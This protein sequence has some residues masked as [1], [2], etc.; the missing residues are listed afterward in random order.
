MKSSRSA[1]SALAGTAIL[2]AAGAPAAAET[3]VISRDDCMRVVRHVPSADVAY[4]PGADVRGRPVAPAD[5][6]AASPLRLPETLSFDLTIDMARYLGG[7]RYGTL[8]S[9]VGTIR[10][11]TASG[12][13]TFGDQPLTDADQRAVAAACQKAYGKVR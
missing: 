13:L 3:V 1:W 11:D 10:Y 9:T 4:A 5:V 8:D 12:R 6:G 7:A 2:A